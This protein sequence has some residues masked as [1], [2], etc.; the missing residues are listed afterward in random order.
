MRATSIFMGRVIEGECGPES[1]LSKTVGETWRLTELKQK[2]SQECRVQTEEELQMEGTGKGTV[3]SLASLFPVE[4][5]QKAAKRVQDAIAEKEKELGRIRGFIADNNNLINLVQK[6]PEELHHD[7]M[8][9]LH[10]QAL[11]LCYGTI[12]CWYLKEALNLGYV[13]FV[14]WSS[15]PVWESSILPRE[16]DTHQ[17]VSGTEFG[18]LTWIVDFPM[19]A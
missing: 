10:N 3:T 11:S 16:F 13:F 2:A 6:L 9:L 18:A 1:Y 14:G 4:D 15:G 8:V 7:I 12:F 17:W 5:A 19:L